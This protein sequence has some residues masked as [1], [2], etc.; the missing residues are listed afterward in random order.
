MLV[1]RGEQANGTFVICHDDIYG[2]LVP[3][4][5]NTG[6]LNENSFY[7][8]WKVNY[9]F[10]FHWVTWLEKPCLLLPLQRNRR[11]HLFLLIWLAFIFI[12]RFVKRRAT[13]ATFIFP[14]L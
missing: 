8:N 9:Q 14:L 7:V 13:I 11:D 2:E 3:D 6:T 5:L 1:S 10:N 4:L 12:Y